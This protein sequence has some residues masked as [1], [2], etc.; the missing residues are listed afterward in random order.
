MIL[1]LVLKKSVKKLDHQRRWMIIINS[2]ILVILCQDLAIVGYQE[3]LSFDLERK[4]VDRAEYGGFYCDR[5]CLA[6]QRFF[7]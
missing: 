2:I 4:A 1:N 3:Q 7:I 6:M 5:K